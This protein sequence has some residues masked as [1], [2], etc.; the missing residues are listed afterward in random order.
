MNRFL[1]VIITAAAMVIYFGYCQDE[2]AMASKNVPQAV[3]GS[4]S[5]TVANPTR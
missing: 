3:S 4:V 1:T 5:P 2:T